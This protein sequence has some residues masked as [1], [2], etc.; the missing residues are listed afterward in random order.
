MP[1]R[2]NEFAASWWA[3]RLDAQHADQRDAFRVSLA[4]RLGEQ[5]KWILECDYDPLGVLLEA[6]REAG[7]ECSGRKWSA[8]GI[9]PK[10][11]M[12]IRDEDGLRSKEGYGGGWQ[13]IGSP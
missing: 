9:L 6:V 1:D 11:T 8:N 7:I 10:K 2:I 5:T 12:L 3:D 13:T 4:T